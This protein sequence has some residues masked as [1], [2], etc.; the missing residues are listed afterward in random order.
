[1]RLVVLAAVALLATATPALAVD[2]YLVRWKKTGFCEIITDTPRFGDHWV[3]LGEFVTRRDA[4]VALQKSRAERQCP[5][6]GASAQ[7]ARDWARKDR[8]RNHA[9]RELE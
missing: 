4:L 8:F 1:M 7:E 6:K 2:Y 9:W 3:Q 5:A